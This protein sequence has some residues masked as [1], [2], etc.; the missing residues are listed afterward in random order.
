MRDFSDDIDQANE[1]AQRMNDHAVAQA[2][3][4]SKPEQVQGQDGSW[5]VTECDE[6]GLDIEPG[7]I[8]L[9]KIR[10]F[11]CQSNLEAVAKQWGSR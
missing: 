3:A 8:A 11:T 9:G 2:R 7:R 6:C 10:C 5:P 4:K 1:L